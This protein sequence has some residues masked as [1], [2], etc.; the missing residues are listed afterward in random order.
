MSK[1]AASIVMAACVYKLM[2]H[3]NTPCIILCEQRPQPQQPQ[4]IAR[5]RGASIRLCT[6]V[7]ESV[8]MLPC[9]FFYH[10]YRSSIEL[11]CRWKLRRVIFFHTT[12]SQVY[13][14]Y[15]NRICNPANSLP[16]RSGCYQSQST[17]TQCLS[18]PIKTNQGC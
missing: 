13:S 14:T 7:D 8:C 17:A 18:G 3:H 16:K 11:L 2:S 4:E 1:R 6:S 12:P 10:L 5:P 9:F 15:L